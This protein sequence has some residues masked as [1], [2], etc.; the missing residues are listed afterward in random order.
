VLIDPLGWHYEQQIYQKRLQYLLDTFYDT[1][2][3]GMFRLSL[4]AASAA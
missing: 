4:K 3:H 2:P 1:L